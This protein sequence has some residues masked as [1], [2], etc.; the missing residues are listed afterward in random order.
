M[1]L[2]EEV[3]NGILSQRESEDLVLLLT[4]ASAHI[5]A[6]VHDIS[7]LFDIHQTNGFSYIIKNPNIKHP[8]PL[9][10]QSHT[11]YQ[12]FLFRYSAMAAFPFICL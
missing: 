1:D 3:R 12:D 10:V 9:P 5:F 6:N 11:L 2:E 8:S 4:K 7:D